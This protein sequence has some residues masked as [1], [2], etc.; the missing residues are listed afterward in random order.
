M[1]SLQESVAILKFKKIKLRYDFTKR[2]LPILLESMDNYKSYDNVK[3]K[4]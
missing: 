3:I 4:G 1:K 2:G